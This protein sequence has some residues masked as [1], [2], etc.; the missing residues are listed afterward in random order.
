MTT[1]HKEAMEHLKV[2]RETIDRS[3]SNRFYR[4]FAYSMGPIFLLSGLVFI[5]GV[6]LHR[7][8]RSIDGSTGV[9]VG[10]WIGALIIMSMMKMFIMR[11]IGKKEDLTLWQ[12]MKKMTPPEFWKVD[13]P[14]EASAVFAVIYCFHADVTQYVIPIILMM[15]GHFMTTMGVLFKIN[16]FVWFG[17]A[18]VA[19]AIFGLFFLLGDILLLSSIALGVAPTIM[20]IIMMIKYGGKDGSRR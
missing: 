5:G 11:N 18:W 15:C 17:Y 1:D 8:L 19:L 4:A 20:G 2:V 12:F 16:L 14:L 7:Y 9:I 6:E 3:T 10:F 13:I